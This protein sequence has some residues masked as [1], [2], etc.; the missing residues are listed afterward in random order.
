MKNKHHIL[1]LSFF[2]L[3][4]FIISG[5]D[6][7]SLLPYADSQNTPVKD[8]SLTVSF[9]DAGQGDATLIEC[10]GEAMLIDA[11]IYSQ[12]DNITSY[13]ADR[14]IKELKYCVAT[15]PHS[16]HIGG[17]SQIILNFDVDTLVYP[18]CESD[19]SGM[20]YVL[21]ACDERG[22]SY[23]NP[24][25]LDTLT[26]GSATITVLSPEAYADYDNI[27]NNSLVLK[28]DYE[29]V[30]FLF[31]GDAETEVERELLSKD[32]D[33]NADV[34]KAGHHGSSTSSSAEFV[35]E[36]T[37][38]VAVISCGKNNDYGHPHRE[39]VNTFSNRDIE[40]YRTDQLSTII[41]ESDG[42]SITFSA[43]G[44]VLS[45]IT[46]NENPGFE[47]SCTGNRN[48]KVFHLDS[49]DSVAKMNEKNKV[50]FKNRKD[51][52]EEGYSPCKSCNP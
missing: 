13:I 11:S 46:A 42:K 19:S 29:D 51:A 16:D 8:A 21:D 49:C 26:L 35:N 33:L 37:P 14:G 41:A 30:S 2:I 9:I 38:S 44:E 5:C 36:V 22:V 17:M 7:E 20:N 34:L 39:T 6:S 48:S 12:R 43:K 1:L 25:P 40:M 47:Y 4:I 28:L 3:I 32:Y 27:N 45:T 10:L 50:H 31:M 18:L 23:L 24:D 15:H 52:V